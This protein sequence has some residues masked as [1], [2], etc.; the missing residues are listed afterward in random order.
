MSSDLPA[1]IRRL[2]QKLARRTPLV[3]TRSNPLQQYPHFYGALTTLT[4]EATVLLKDLFDPA[5]SDTI[6]FALQNLESLT[7]TH[8]FES[9][10]LPL[11]F[12]DVLEELFN[13]LKS[14]FKL[15][16]LKIDTFVRSQPGHHLSMP[17]C[18]SQS[19]LPITELSLSDTHGLSLS[20]LLNYIQA[21]SIT[22]NS[23]RFT[24]PLPTCGSLTI[25]RIE[26][27]SGVGE[28]LSQWNGGH[29]AIHSCPFLDER[30]I[31]GEMRRMYESGTPFLPGVQGISFQGSSDAVARRM[32]ELLHLRSQLVM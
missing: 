7:I 22:L 2:G 28:V 26:P 23:C 12:D 24:D 14:L 1:P 13:F 30:F 18:I 17:H 27:F 4:I 32:R 25:E 31:Q 19:F 8:V 21:H 6:Y 10:C 3:I 16:Y 29:L 5:Q 15:R 11:D 20:F 9:S